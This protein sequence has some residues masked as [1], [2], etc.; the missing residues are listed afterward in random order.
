MYN[1]NKKNT[2]PAMKT[3][4]ITMDPNTMPSPTKMPKKKK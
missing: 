2:N 1:M 4:K 3:K